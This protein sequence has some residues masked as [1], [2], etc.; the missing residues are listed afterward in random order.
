M[1]RRF[2]PAWFGALCLAVLPAAAAAQGQAVSSVLAGFG[3]FGTWA[4]Q[5]GAP[6]SAA[7]VVQTVG[8]TGRE[9]VEFSATAVAGA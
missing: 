4:V 6:P 7:N 1:L 5:C 2:W 9:P 8:W 3:F